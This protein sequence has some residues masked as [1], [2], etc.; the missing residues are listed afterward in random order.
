MTTKKEKI[1]EEQKADIVTTE[2]S[3]KVL[4]TQDGAGAGM[5]FEED[6]G[7]GVENADKSS[8]AIPFITLMQAL[9]PQVNGESPL[10]GAKAGKFINNITNEIFDEV[11]FIPCAF[12]RTFI[13]WATGRGGFKGDFKPIDVETGRL[14]GM[15]TH[16]GRHLMDVVP[17]QPVFDANGRS[18][19]D[20][21]SDTRNHFVLY[22]AKN[23]TWQPAIMSLSSTQIKKSKRLMSLITGIEITGK[24]DVP[25]NPPS[26]SHI[27]TASPAYEKNA[28]GAWWGWDFKLQR[29]LESYESIVYAKAKAFNKSVLDGVVKVE[30]PAPESTDS[31]NFDAETGECKF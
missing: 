17:G 24:N 21:L 12:Q 18:L 16:N 5:D 10:E 3:N 30:P 29:T 9:S 13:R 7:A 15:S 20:E 22:R 26:F 11:E 6:A 1:V 25:F 2:D 14:E 4:T 23:G 8:F 31:P 19:Y 27:Y 28:K